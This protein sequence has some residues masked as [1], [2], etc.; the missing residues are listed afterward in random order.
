MNRW[1]S[2]PPWIITAILGALAIWTVLMIV[3]AYLRTGSLKR[4]LVTACFVLA[5]VTLWLVSLHRAR[6][7]D[8]CNPRRRNIS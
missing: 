4:G 1:A 8:K 6:K 5:F 3:G 7:R 2:R